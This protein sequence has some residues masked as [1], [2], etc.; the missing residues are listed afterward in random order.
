[1][2]KCNEKCEVYSRVTG[3]FRP[4]ANWNKGKKEEFK[5]RKMFNVGKA[6]LLLF[7]L[8][9][10]AL[11]TGC[12]HNMVSYGDG[13]MLETTINPETYAF[14]ISLRYGKILTAC[15]RE[16]T[17]IE[18][19]GGNNTTGGGSDK[20]STAAKTDASVK[21]KVGKQITGY[22]VDAIK[23]GAKPEEVDKYTAQDK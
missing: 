11:V 6:V 20:G 19:S 7:G 13:I 10:L 22:Y 15:V 16:N 8:L 2:E 23:A 21:L 4:V 18:M 9:A 14:G 17:E 12:G 1:M 3:Y 5:D